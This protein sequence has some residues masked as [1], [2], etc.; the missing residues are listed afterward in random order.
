MPRAK[1][2]NDMILS[3]IFDVYIKKNVITTEMGIAA[4][5]MRVLRRFLRK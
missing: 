5:I 4:P 3:E 2:P 1:P